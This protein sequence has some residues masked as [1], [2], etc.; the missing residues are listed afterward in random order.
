MDIHEAPNFRRMSTLVT[1][2]GL[3][4]ED[5]LRGLASEGYEVVVN[6]LPDDSEH[7][8]PDEARIVDDSGLDYVH[9]PVDFAA[10]T[11]ADLERFREVMDAN[12]GRKLHIHCAANARVSA[13]Y[14]MYLHRTGRC[15]AA[16]A[17][18]IVRDVWDPSAHPV[19]QEL[20]ADELSEDEDP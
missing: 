18:A 2:S 3:V 5:Q 4:S 12:D 10:P 17:D 11:S 14:A 19:W 9:I 8:L 15:S 7:A 6:L 13:F 20:L 16:D 1:T